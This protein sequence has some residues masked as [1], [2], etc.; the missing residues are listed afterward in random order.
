MSC[1]RCCNK[2]RELKQEDGRMLCDHCIE[3]MRKAKLHAERKNVWSIVIC[4]PL[5]KTKREANAT[6]R[7]IQEISLTNQQ[8]DK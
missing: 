8:G 5:P 3:I 1:A 6:A 4:S 2:Y 7:D